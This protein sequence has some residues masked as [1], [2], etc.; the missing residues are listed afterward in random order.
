MTKSP[1]S[2]LVLPPDIVSSEIRR[3]L[4]KSSASN[5]AAAI[6]MDPRTLCKVAAGVSVHHL[7]VRTIMLWLDSRARAA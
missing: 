2:A 4:S 5:I 7:T 6:G 3:L 1:A